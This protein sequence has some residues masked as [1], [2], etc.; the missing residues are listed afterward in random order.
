[1][2]SDLD[3]VFHHDQSTVEQ[4]EIAHGAMPRGADGKGTASVNRN[5]VSKNNRA[6]VL[7]LQMAKNLCGFAIKAVA[8]FDRCPESV[9]P[10]SRPRSSGSAVYVSHSG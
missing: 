7:G 6:F 3:P 1:M 9:C 10:T 4:G 2:R 5:V 8:E